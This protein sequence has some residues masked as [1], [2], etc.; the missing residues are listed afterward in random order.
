MLQGLGAWARNRHGHC[1]P[2]NTIIISATRSPARESSWR[3]STTAGFTIFEAVLVVLI[4]FVIAATLIPKFGVVLGHSRVNRAANVIAA[5]LMLAQ[6]LAGRQHA[7]VVVTIS[8]DSL[9]L[10]I[11]QA[12]PAGT[13][14]RTFRFDASSDFNLAA[15]TATPPSIQVMPNGTTTSVMVVTIGSPSD[16]HHQVTMTVAGQVRVTQ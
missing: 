5:Q 2:S 6:T 10:Q 7:P 15:L 9:S 16:Y 11:S 1:S 12:P 3:D 4:V 13:L 8:S 14:L